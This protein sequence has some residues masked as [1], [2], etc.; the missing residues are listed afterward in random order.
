M[1]H[2]ADAQRAADAARASDGREGP[3]PCTPGGFEPPGRHALLL[4]EEALATA[5]ALRRLGLIGSLS[6]IANF[7]QSADVKLRAR[8]APRGRAALAFV[9]D[10]RLRLVE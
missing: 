4:V 1:E 2:A 6:V 9:L 8:L 5:I 7:G 10:A 3:P